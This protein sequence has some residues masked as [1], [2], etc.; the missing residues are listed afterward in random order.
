MCSVTAVVIFQLWKAAEVLLVCQTAEN[1]PLV[2]NSQLENHTEPQL[3]LQLSKQFNKARRETSY[4]K[5]N[6]KL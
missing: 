3:S 2:N 4:C 5:R 1:N 6:W